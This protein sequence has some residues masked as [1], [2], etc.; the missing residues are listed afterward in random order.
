MPADDIIAAGWSRSRIGGVLMRLYSE[1][2]GS[3]KL[4]IVWTAE[5]IRSYRHLPAQP[6]SPVHINGSP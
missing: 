4:Q 2:D 5:S 3:S 1:F 6:R